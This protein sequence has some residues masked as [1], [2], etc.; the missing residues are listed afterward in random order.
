MKRTFLCLLATLS[1]TGSIAAAAQPAITEIATSGIGSVS[2][3]PDT[4]TVTAM[5][6]TNAPSASDA[7]SQSNQIYDRVVAGLAKLGIARDDIS[8][9]YYNV[10]YNPRP[11]VVP[12]DV[13]GERF[14]Y[15]VS[16][17]FRVKVRKIGEAGAVTDACIASGAT[18]ISGVYF[19]LSNSD[20]ARAQ[21]ITKAVANA[22][23]NASDLARTA[24]LRIV[25]IKSIE[26]ADNGYVAPQGMIARVETGTAAPTDFDQ[27]NVAVVVSVKIVFIAEP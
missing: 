23:G 15:T 21:A 24:G 25:S 4:A 11:Q 5:V 17:S 22:R 7:S 1:L 9:T 3:P 19:G 16:R 6:E 13:S 26:L 8:L 12:A 27:S 18:S 10:R 2:L 20:A 14:G